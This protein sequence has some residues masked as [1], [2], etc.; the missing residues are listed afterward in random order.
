MSRRKKYKVEEQEKNDR[1][2]VSYADFITL[3]F[4]FFVVMYSVSSVNEGKYRVLSDSISSAFKLSQDGISVQ[5]ESPLKPPIIEHDM[6]I[7]NQPHVLIKN[8]YPKNWAGTLENEKAK[9]SLNRISARVENSLAKLIDKNLVYVKKN[10]LW[11]EVEI[12]SSILFP[13]GSSYL[14]DDSRPLLKELAEVL[15]QYGN[16]IQVEG[17]TDNVPISTSEF[18]S[19]WE[20][21]TSRAA[22]VVRLL[23]KEGVDPKRMSA[24]GYG[25]FRPMASNATPQGRSKNR[26]VKII[27]LSNS[28]STGAEESR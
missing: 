21:S 3:L 15:N 11:I 19:N 24:V 9:D 25:Q 14:S 8:N 16:Q 5:L 2:L 4:A 10:D 26:R 27:I 22:S 18:P 13:S 7:S 12:K 20:L 23:S 17:F 28:F 6:T 1:W